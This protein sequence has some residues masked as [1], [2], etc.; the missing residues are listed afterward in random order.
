MNF[1]ENC[2][3]ELTEKHCLFLQNGWAFNRYTYKAVKL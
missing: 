1:L 3:K 2:L